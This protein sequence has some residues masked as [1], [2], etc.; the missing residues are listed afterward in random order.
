MNLNYYD[1][2]GVE[3]LVENYFELSFSEESVPFQSTILPLALTNF[4]YIFSGN[5]FALVDGSKIPLERLIVSGQFFRSYKFFVN[6]EGRSFGVS[7]HPTALYKLLGIDISRL[8]NKHVPLYEVHQDFHDKL[9]PLFKSYN[10]P[11]ETIKKINAILLES[12]LFE[13]KNSIF[14]DQAIHN[15]KRTE[16]M[17]QIEELL[18]DLPF[19]QKSLETHFKKIV[20]L[21]PGKYI[22][23]YRFFHLMRKYESQQIELKDLIYMYD[24]Y[25]QSH[26]AKDFKLFMSES[27]HSY[28]K[29]DYPFIKKYLVH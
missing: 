24:Y 20:G 21:T 10:N 8:T 19:S 25:D 1:T 28:F 27:P 6:S 13:D 7:F 17:I 29:K 16:G 26:F 15:I 3:H 2:T 22:R 23:L 11:T 4:T 5:Q 18:N 12:K 9:S 14:I